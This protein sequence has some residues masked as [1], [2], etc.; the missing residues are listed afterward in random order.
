MISQT[1]EYA[2]RAVVCLV[3]CPDNTSIVSEIATITKVPPSYLSK[4]LQ[5]LRKARIVKSQRGLYG[6]FKLA[7]PAEKISLLEVVNAVDPIQTIDSCPL[8]LEA[9]GNGLCALHKRLND[10][11]VLTQKA[12]QE[13]SVHEFLNCPDRDLS[14]CK[15]LDAKKR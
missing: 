2:L 5:S 12:F 8:N 6:G 7:K 11:I 9:H 4:V 14:L 10:T 1:A 13:S 15:V 3:N